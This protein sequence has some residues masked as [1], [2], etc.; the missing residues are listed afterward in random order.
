MKIPKCKMT[1][2]GKHKWG[3]YL[4]N[5]KYK[6]IREGF[7]LIVIGIPTY[8]LIKCDFCQMVDDRKLKIE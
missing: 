4:S 2:S 8:N 1:I 7:D 6:T 3:K 5:M